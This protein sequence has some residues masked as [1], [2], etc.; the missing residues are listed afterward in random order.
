MTNEDYLNLITSEHRGKEK[1]EATV[2]AG[3]S[4][5]SKLQVIMQG[6]PADFDID[7]A[8]G[9]QLDAVGIW[10]GFSRA[11]SVPLTGVY[12]SFDTTAQEGWD[13]G[14]WK[15]EFD[16]ENGPIFLT[17]DEYRLA[18]KAKILK[19]SWDGTIPGAL[20]IFGQVF[21]QDAFILIQDGQDMTMS[22]LIAGIELSAVEKQILINDSLLPKP[23]GV[24]LAEVLFTDS[25]APIFCF[26]AESEKLGGFDRGSWADVLFT[27]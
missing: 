6:L 22:I 21:G 27:F 16:P 14:R 10:V 7:Q 1:F 5:F 24:R 25:E 15:D 9:V 20:Q 23:E 18:I 4:P 26:D 13:S 2:V 8:V 12:F 19:N 17:D 3:V 11:V